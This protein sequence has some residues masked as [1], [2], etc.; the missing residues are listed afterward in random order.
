MKL[1]FL[2]QFL[3]NAQMSNLMKIHPVGAELSMWI[4]RW[5]DMTKLIFAFCDLKMCLNVLCVCVCVCVCVFVCV[6]MYMCACTR[7]VVLYLKGVWQYEGTAPHSLPFALS[8]N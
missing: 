2:Q 5:T 3:K 8:G 6:R 7:E 1:E 4:Y